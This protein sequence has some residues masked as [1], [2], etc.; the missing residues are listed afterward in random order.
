M[1]PDLMPAACSALKCQTES[2]QPSVEWFDDSTLCCFTSCMS[3]RACVANCAPCCC[4]QGETLY[5]VP[6]EDM[7]FPCCCFSNRV[8]TC[9]FP[10]AGTIGSCCLCLCRDNPV[11]WCCSA[12][13]CGLS[14]CGVTCCAEMCAAC[15]GNCCECC[16][17][18]TGAPK[19]KLQFLP[20]GLKD[21][22]TAKET[23]CKINAA[24]KQYFGYA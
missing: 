12:V 3:C 15:D 4:S 9:G 16:G 10:C 23:A 22:Q 24:L 18:P 13:T 8:S 14:F 17:Q 20:G 5:I 7:P 19:M 1:I 21:E 2:T 6:Y 11:G